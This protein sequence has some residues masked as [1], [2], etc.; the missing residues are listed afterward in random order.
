MKKQTE[1][2]KELKNNPFSFLILLKKNSRAFLFLLLFIVAP[3]IILSS[4]TFEYFYISALSFLFLFLAYTITFLFVISYITLNKI[5]NQDVISFGKVFKLIPSILPQTILPVLLFALAITISGR[6]FFFAPLILFVFFPIV[7]F[8]TFFKSNISISE[9]ISANFKFNNT[10]EGKKL[11]K[12][13]FIISAILVFSL[14][15]INFIFSGIFSFT[16]G[17]LIYYVTISVFKSTLFVIGFIALHFSAT[18][19]YA[20]HIFLVPEDTLNTAN[21]ILADRRTTKR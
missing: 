18:K 5:S 10:D 8:I 21:N 17:S 3:L 2:N 15:I 19:A 14:G 16:Y 13:T 1:F 9:I 20:D 12:N 7:S 4:I 6:F 11:T